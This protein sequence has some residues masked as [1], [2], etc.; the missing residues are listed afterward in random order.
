[1]KKYKIK[2]VMWWNEFV[3]GR[4]IAH[5]IDVGDSETVETWGS[6]RPDGTLNIMFL[7]KLKN[8]NRPVK[9]D[10]P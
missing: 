4:T 9:T 5:G 10:N 7:E 3:L 1:M 2:I 8:G 6:F